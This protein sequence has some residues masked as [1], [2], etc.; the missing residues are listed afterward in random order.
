M[1]DGYYFVHTFIRCD[2]Q[3]GF[4]NP[5][6]YLPTYVS[7]NGLHVFKRASICVQYFII[8]SCRC[9]IALFNAFIEKLA[10]LVYF[11]I[12]ILILKFNVG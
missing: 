2:V 1:H 4:E 3:T 9:K 6:D 8:A 11:V 12:T 7:D 5:K 10:Y